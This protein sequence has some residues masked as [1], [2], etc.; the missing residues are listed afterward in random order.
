MGS[1]AEVDFGISILAIANSHSLYGH[2]F[3]HFRSRL[4]FDLSFYINQ[5]FYDEKKENKFQRFHLFRLLS[6]YIACRWLLADIKTIFWRIYYGIFNKKLWDYFC[7]SRRGTHL[8]SI[9]NGLF[10]K[11]ITKIS[12]V[13]TEELE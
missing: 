9:C 7:C 4:P 5:L 8:F 11:I 12:R 2:Y 6:S 3:I 1:I 13:I 10:I